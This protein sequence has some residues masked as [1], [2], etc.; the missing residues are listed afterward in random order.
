MAAPLSNGHDPRETL[1]RLLTAV[2]GRTR[3]ACALDLLWIDPKLGGS[4]D[5]VTRA[6]VAMALNAALFL[7]LLDRVPTA[8]RY[9]E[10]LR[11]KGETMA[12]DHGA[13]RT[14]DGGTGELP[15]GCAAFTR[16][17]APLGY[18]AAGVYPLP[19]LKMTGLALVQRDM[20]ESVPQFFV[21]ELHVR[22]LPEEAQLAA[23]RVFGRSRDPLGPAEW[24]AL[25]GLDRDGSCAT[26]QAVAIVRG[27][28]RAFGRQHPMPSLAD[29][30]TLLRHSKE[31]A[32]IATEGNAFNHATTRTAD[33]EQLAEDLRKAG[34]SMK[35]AVEVS[36]NGRVRQ[37][38]I[39]ADK[40]CRSFRLSDGSEIQRKVPGSFY[41]FITRDIDPAT[42]MLDLT[43]DSGNATGIFAVTRE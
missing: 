14:I 29:Y 21:S 11:E 33:V 34:Y 27:A 6:Q 24:A 4:A 18:E 5:R 16:F 35:P 7:D 8:A 25:E 32:W 30:E 19:K 36:R 3:S 41:E 39:I 13:L 9:V 22:E 37:T 2:V 20:P 40:V 28:L 10:S 1:L 26:E 17:L 12:F 43:F 38:A 42:G 23:E 15:S 31:A